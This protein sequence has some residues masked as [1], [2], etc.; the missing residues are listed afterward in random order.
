MNVPLKKCQTPESK[1]EAEE[2][3]SDHD[4]EDDESPPPTS[5]KPK[6]LVDKEDEEEDAKDQ[7]PTPKKA[8][9]VAPVASAAMAAPSKQAGKKDQLP[10]KHAHSKPQPLVKKTPKSVAFIE[11]SDVEQGA[12]GASKKSSGTNPTAS[13]SKAIGGT[14]GVGSDNDN[15]GLPPA[16]LE[17]R[18]KCQEDKD[19]TAAIHTKNAEDMAKR[20]AG[21][22]SKGPQPKQKSKSSKEIN[23]DADTSFEEDE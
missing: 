15:E 23:E 12:T 5:K 13:S 20:A 16:V 1:D 3:P 22:G 8:K 4:D 18:K 9:L 11:D 6:R 2:T 21:M 17:A 19:R 10:S 7:D 14:G